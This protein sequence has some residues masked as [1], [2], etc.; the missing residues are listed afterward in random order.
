MK[1]I[2]VA[3]L[4]LDSNYPDLADVSAL[5]DK[6][7]NPEFIDQVNWP[8]FPYHPEVFFRIAWLSQEISIKFY[9]KEDCVK[10]ELTETNQPVFQDS[11]VEFFVSPADD[12]IY[13]NLEFNCIGTC[14]IG[15][16]TS[17]KNWAVADPSIAETVRTLPSLGQR[18]FPERTGP[19]E[20]TLTIAVPLKIFLIE[21]TKPNKIV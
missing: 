10:A 21:H 2:R 19:A 5:M 9:V 4:P 20:W 17:K 3:K 11:C 15:S 14:L 8:S 7:G 6:S 1:S 16:G 18:P 13:Y 12:G